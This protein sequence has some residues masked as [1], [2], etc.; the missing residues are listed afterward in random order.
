MPKKVYIVKAVRSDP[1]HHP[2][3]RI[4]LCTEDQDDARHFQQSCQKL[5]DKMKAEDPPTLLKRYTEAV[6][7]WFRWLTSHRVREVNE[8]KEAQTKALQGVGRDMHIYD[9]GLVQHQEDITHVS[10]TSYEVE[11]QDL[12]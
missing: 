4:V 12:A 7:R 11:E 5:T 8:F 10:A 1:D 9:P 3:E 2:Y 6:E